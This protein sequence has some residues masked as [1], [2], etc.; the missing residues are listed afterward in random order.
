M[1]RKT[2]GGKKPA[3]AKVDPSAI[4]GDLKHLMVSRAAREVWV[5]LCR[6]RVLVNPAPR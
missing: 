2:R 6:V 3:I 5:V 1:A 4:S